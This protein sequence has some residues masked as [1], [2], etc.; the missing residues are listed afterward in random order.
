MELGRCEVGD[1]SRGAA[2][3]YLGHGICET[4]WDQFTTEEAQPETLRMALGIEAPTALPMEEIM[5][6]PKAG[7]RRGKR[8]GNQQA[9][10]KPKAIRP[11]RASKKAGSD[12]AQVVFAFRLALADRDRIHQA[13]GP[14][15]ATQFV[16]SAALAA[17]SADTRAFEELV[18]K[19]KANQK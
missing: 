17:A 6:V 4:H 15:G 9:A 18:E 12:E 2:I 19:A 11:A 1:C 8:S 3:T 13:A 7:T 14:G 10:V 5:T 16:R